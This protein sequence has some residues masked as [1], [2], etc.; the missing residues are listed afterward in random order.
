MRTLCDEVAWLEHGKLIDIGPPGQIIDGYLAE[1]F[2]DAPS[3]DGLVRWG[4]GEV[5]DRAGRD[6]RRV[7]SYRSPTPGPVTTSPCDSTTSRAKPV[8]DAVFGLAVHTNTGIEVT[9]PN[10]RHAG[11][12]AE[13]VEGT[14]F[15]DFR[16]P[17][18][19]LVPGA[20]DVVAVV[21]DFSCTHPYD[22]IQNSLRFEVEAGN[23][24]EENGIVSLGGEWSGES[25][26]RDR[27]P[28]VGGLTATTTSR[29][30]VVVTGEVLGP[31]MAGP[32]I[33]AVHMARALAT[34][35]T[36]DLVTTNR[37]HSV[38]GD[39]PGAPC[40][41][42]RAGSARA[43]APMW[44]W[45]R[46]MRC[47]GHP[48]YATST[49]RWWST[50]TT[51]ST[52]R[53]RA[54]APPRPGHAAGARSAPRP[55]S[56]NEQIRRGDFF[57][58]ASARAARLLARPPRGARAGQPSTPTTPTGTL[59]ADRRRA[60][61][62]RG[63]A[64]RATARRR[65]GVSS[66]GIGA[67]DEIVLWG[68]GIYNWFD[69]LTAIRAVDRLRHASPTCPPVLRRRRAPQR[70][71]CREMQMATRARAARRRPRAHRHVTCSSTSWVAY[72]E[73][74]NYLL[75]ADIGVSSH[76]DHVET[77]F[78]FRTRMLDYLWAGLPMVT[79]Q[80][81]TLAGADRSGGRRDRGAARGPRR[82]R[83]RA[84]AAAR[85]RRAPGG[86]RRRGATR[87]GG[88]PVVGGAPAGGR[89]LRRPGRSP[90]LRDPTPPCA[91]AHGR[92]LLAAGWRERLPAPVRH[93]A[94]R[95]R[96]SFGGPA[97]EG[98]GDR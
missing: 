9:G 3:E 69:P 96:H 83:G 46:A 57:L 49:R 51:R 97:P 36:V 66:P 26:P 25:L 42:A 5:Q 53:A 58:C 88:V 72:D 54:D 85:R 7:R 28:K 48:G 8:V 34:D 59:V 60:V 86:L 92:D 39:A 52:S 77:A 62:R 94:R 33:R 73:R 70:R 98:S 93:A 76:L 95:V 29:R 18:L 41:A 13:R 1:T 79:T 27:S 91:I 90:D 68:G 55:T 87:G 71:A 67:D 20:Y 35:H 10:V 64:A 44:S 78:S 45:C 50:S 16:V 81:D 47:V 4:S 82:A 15:V 24:Y 75:E 65:C 63:R 80:G 19:L 40:G 12:V 30:I 37:S 22:H 31:Q 43:P 6:A 2:S 84:R 21:Y 38:V 74:Q 89:L 23:P 61:R 14:G 32:A 56:L 11:L 17:R